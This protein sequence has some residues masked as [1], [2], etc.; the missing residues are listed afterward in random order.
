MNIDREINQDQ[1]ISSDNNISEET[2]EL[3]DINR[4]KCSSTTHNRTNHKDCPLN[5]KN[6]NQTSTDIDEIIDSVVSSTLLIPSS[7]FLQ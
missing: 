1:F 5:K 6:L 7:G 3:I 2:P 4:C